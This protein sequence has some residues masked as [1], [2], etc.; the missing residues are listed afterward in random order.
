MDPCNYQGVEKKVEMT[1]VFRAQGAIKQI[2]LPGLNSLQGAV[3]E[4]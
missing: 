3:K 4:G 2:C 1:A